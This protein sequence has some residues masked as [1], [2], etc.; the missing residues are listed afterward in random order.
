MSIS[1]A[2]RAIKIMLSVSEQESVLG[3][4]AA[5][6]LAPEFELDCSDTSASGLCIC[7]LLIL[8]LMPHLVSTHAHRYSLVTI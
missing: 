8:S 3:I 1:W 4:M 2:H 6:A 5:T 7:Y